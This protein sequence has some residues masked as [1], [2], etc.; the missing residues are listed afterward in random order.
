MFCVSFAQRLP[1]LVE[2]LELR[3]ERLLSRIDLHEFL[4][5]RGVGLALGVERREL[6]LQLF[7][8]AL[9]ALARSRGV[10]GALR[11]WLRLFFALDGLGRLLQGGLARAVFTEFF[12][13]AA[14]VPFSSSQMRV[15]NFSMKYRSCDTNSSAC[16]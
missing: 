11:L 14:I 10:R 16:V 13:R 4:I 3:I 8:L 7:D 15:A 2:R 1:R 6:P 5:V 9:R 12:V